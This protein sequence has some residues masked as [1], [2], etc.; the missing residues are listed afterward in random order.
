MPTLP[1]A[2]PSWENLDAEDWKWRVLHLNSLN[3]FKVVWSDQKDRIFSNG[4]EVKD[5]LDKGR[6]IFSNCTRSDTTYPKG[7]RQLQQLL[8]K[9]EGFPDDYYYYWLINS[10]IIPEDFLPERHPTRQTA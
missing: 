5:W 8:R 10:K 3:L 7:R 9:E 4:Q 1:C 2:L 6:F